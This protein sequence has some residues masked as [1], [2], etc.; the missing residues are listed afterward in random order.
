MMKRLCLGLSVI[1]L[2]VLCA[3]PC[4]AR[5]QWVIGDKAYDVDTLIFPHL[6]GPGVIAAKYDIPALPLKV[7]VVEMDLTN[8]YIVM[9]TCLGA[10][11]S[12]GT[13]TPVNMA[14]RNTPAAGDESPHRVRRAGDLHHIPYH[15]HGDDRFHYVPRLCSSR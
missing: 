1:A 15:N 5:D 2:L 9:E 3:E 4:F 13:E 12:V 11:K 6:A 8:P 7:S 10:E 14:I